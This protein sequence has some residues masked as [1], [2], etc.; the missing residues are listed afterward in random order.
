MSKPLV[1]ICMITY[2]HDA[3]IIEA[4]QGVLK[5][6]ISFDFEFII[7]NDASTD[8]T[9]LYIQEL[10][11]KHPEVN[12]KYYNHSKNKG[13][14]D[15]FLFAL[16]SCSGKYIALCEG[17]DYWTDSMKLQ[18][19]IDFLESNSDYE[20][21]FT[22]IE[23]VNSSGRKVKDKLISNPEKYSYTHKDMVIWAPTLTRVFLNRD[24]SVLNKPSPG[25]DTLMLVYQSNLG[26]IRFLDE[27]TGAYRVHEGG[28]YS[29][30]DVKRKYEHK[31]KTSIACLSFVQKE[32]KK[33]YAGQ[34]LKNLLELKALDIKLYNQSLTFFLNEIQILNDISISK[35]ISFWFCIILVRQ[36]IIFK[37][38]V[39]RDFYKKIINRLL[40]Y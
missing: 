12:F 4:I 13:M 5:Q 2:N 21:C 20:M 34:I 36:P 15:N 7:A 9:D 30:I 29:E 8:N 17:D 37:H 19:Q 14:I 39:A 24:F 26:K 31:I 6:I 18:K 38:I 32:Y 10:I 27:V 1:S 33:K 16:A 25:M 23:V 22:N 28:V 11:K 40:V 35:K 3:F